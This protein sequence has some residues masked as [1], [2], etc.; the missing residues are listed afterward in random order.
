MWKLLE[1]DTLNNIDIC[2]FPEILLELVIPVNSTHT[3]TMCK[4]K[5]TI[6]THVVDILETVVDLDFNCEFYARIQ[7]QFTVQLSGQQKW[8]NA[9]LALLDTSLSVEVEPEQY[10]SDVDVLWSVSQMFKGLNQSN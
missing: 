2:S 8:K 10:P 3:V 7:M 1:M 5:L 4:W 6:K 9:Q